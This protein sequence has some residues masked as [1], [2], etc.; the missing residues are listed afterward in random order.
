[1]AK[2]IVAVRYVDSGKV[3]LYQFPS[4]KNAKEFTHD[5]DKANQEKETY[6]Y[7]IQQ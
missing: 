5:L 1:M 2:T 6:Q 7:L 3:E 4:K